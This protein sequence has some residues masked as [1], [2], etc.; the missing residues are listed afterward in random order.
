MA[1]DVVDT[2]GSGL[3]A[4][5]VVR[6]VEAVL[7]KEGREGSVEVAFVDREE[8]AALNDR[9]RDPSGPTDVLSFPTADDRDWPAQDVELGQLVVCLEVVR[10]YAQEDGVAEAEQSGWT[11]VHGVLHLLGYDHETDTGEMRRREQ[12][13]L[14]DLRAEV[15][16]LGD[17][18][19]RSDHG[20]V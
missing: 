5:A 6:L 9:Y 2:T 20:Q 8:I 4:E 19:D 18:R 17:R 7:C 14:A 13:L 15:A 16:A 11:L 12:V 1:V 3:P 10:R